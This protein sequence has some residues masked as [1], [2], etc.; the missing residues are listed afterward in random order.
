MKSKGHQVVLLD[1]YLGVEYDNLD[2][3][4]DDTRDWAEGMKAVSEKNP[5]MDELK[6]LKK[7]DMDFF[8][9]QGNYSH[10]R[11]KIANKLRVPTNQTILL[12]KIK[13]TTCQK[14]H[15]TSYAT[16]HPCRDL[17]KPTHRN[18]YQK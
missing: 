11:Y 6:A 2:V 13:N 1:V 8:G 12:R 17:C 4:F 18:T 10:N 7:G 5:T 16:C 9:N 14:N 3:I 15:H